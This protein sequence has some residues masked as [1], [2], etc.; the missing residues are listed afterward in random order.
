M[1]MYDLGKD[2]VQGSR[3]S[4]APGCD[5]Q[6]TRYLDNQGRG[7]VSY[8]VPTFP[9]TQTSCPFRLMSVPGQRHILDTVTEGV[10]SGTCQPNSIS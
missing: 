4:S 8:E 9:L 3:T 10:M 2:C 7:V 5:E 1:T 6:L